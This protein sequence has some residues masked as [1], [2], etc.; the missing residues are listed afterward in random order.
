M[1]KNPPAN[2]GDTRDAGLIPGSRR[3]PGVGN[4]NPLQYSCLKNSTDIG[5]WWA[6]VHRGCKESDTTEWL[7]TH[8][9]KNYYKS[10]SLLFLL[11]YMCTCSCVCTQVLGTTRHMIV[12][13]AW[14]R[15]QTGVDKWATCLLHNSFFCPSGLITSGFQFPLKTNEGAWS[16][17]AP[18]WSLPFQSPWEVSG[19]DWAGKGTGSVWWYR[20]HLQL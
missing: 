3:S 2:A 1:V 14:L 8:I 7:S 10:P 15:T 17:Q 20:W 4:S 12:T 6:T 13:G 5:A 19:W 18:F 11:S 9:N 16:T